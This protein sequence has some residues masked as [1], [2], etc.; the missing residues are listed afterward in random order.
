MLLVAAAAIIAVS[1]ALTA[2]VTPSAFPPLLGVAVMLGLGTA[3]PRLLDAAARRDGHWQAY[4][5]LDSEAVPTPHPDTGEIAIE[6]IQV[7]LDRTVRSIESIERRALFIPGAIGVVATIALPSIDLAPLSGYRGWTFGVLTGALAAAAIQSTFACLLHGR[8]HEFQLVR[9]ASQ[10]G[11]E[12][13]AYRAQLAGELAHAL[14]HA[15]FDEFLKSSQLRNA[16]FFAIGA[17]V[18]LFAYVVVGSVP[19]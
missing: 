13:K 11:N 3:L 5:E 9:S 6:P 17:V 14:R 15:T 19:S 4:E 10:L 12:P 8:L 7:L 18:F 1:L 16:L 2:I